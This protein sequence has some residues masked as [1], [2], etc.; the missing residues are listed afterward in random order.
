[1][2]VGVGVT[3]SVGVGVIVPALI[4]T[5]VLLFRRAPLGYLLAPVLL[6]FTVVLGIGL[7]AAGIAQLLANLVS[8][9]QFIGF[10]A[11]DFAVI[12]GII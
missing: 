2:K 10:T 7:T 3:V 12:F 5:G 4:L 11:G 8:I 6:V 1:V 9:G